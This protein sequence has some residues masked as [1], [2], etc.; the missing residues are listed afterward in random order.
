MANII[1][2]IAAIV[3][4]LALV[5]SIAVVLFSPSSKKVVRS[6]E[7][8]LR[9]TEE[10]E[11]AANRVLKSLEAIGQPAASARVVEVPR[12]VFSLF[13][14]SVVVEDRDPERILATIRSERILALIRAAENE[15]RLTY[16]STWARVAE[17]HTA[18]EPT[19]W[20]LFPER[21]ITRSTGDDDAWNATGAVPQLV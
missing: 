9:S 8:A 17:R 2:L 6:Q 15:R 19:P 10:A 11:E 14:D 3:S 5:G 20:W 4:V 21:P 7:R 16:S 13:S 18:P 12:P 1:V